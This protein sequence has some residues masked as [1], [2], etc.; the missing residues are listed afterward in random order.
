MI[1]PGSFGRDATL[2]GLV[3]I[4]PWIGIN[5]SCDLD[6]GEEKATGGEAGPLR[7]VLVRHAEA[8]RNLPSWNEVPAEKLD[9]LTPRGVLQADAVGRALK[10]KGAGVAA[11]LT[12]PTGRARQT[13]VGLMK[14]LGLQGAPEEEAAINACQAGESGK[15]KEA[16]IRGAIE[17]LV[18]KYPG[19]TVVIVTHQHL[20]RLALKR[21]APKGKKGKY[22]VPASPP[23]SMAVLL[24]L[25]DAWKI[26]KEPEVVG[27]KKEESEKKKK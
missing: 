15:D 14:A 1:T 21:A 10:E 26:E 11:V 23:G 17:S 16:R 24:V 9:T 12:A 25:K 13:A 7:L 6:A 3:F 27:V 4:L 22:K 2:R 19:K 18:K 20:I 5:V 8:Y